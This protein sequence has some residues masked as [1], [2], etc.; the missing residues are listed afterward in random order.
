MAARLTSTTYRF[1]TQRALAFDR[2][3]AMGTNIGLGQV[4]D[5]PISQW[6][7]AFLPARLQAHVRGVQIRRADGSTRPLVKNE[8]V[9]FT[10]NRLPEPTAPPN[11][12]FRNL[13][14][15]LAIAAMLGLL[16]RAARNG[17]RAGASGLLDRRHHMGRPQ[18]TPRRHLSSSAGRRRG[19]RSWRATRTCC[20]SI[21]C[22]S[23]WR[24]CCRLP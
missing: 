11:V 14:I 19:T 5:R 12:L 17:R 8:Q 16:A 18:R 21:R 4:A 13:V 6:E 7:E 1:H 24:F 3:V 15:G 10:A 22:P 2:A 9:L 20:S 23:A